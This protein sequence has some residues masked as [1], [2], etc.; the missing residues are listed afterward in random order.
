MHVSLESLP[1]VMSVEQ[2]ASYLGVCRATAYNWCKAGELP[3][4][5]VGNTRRIRKETF[6]VWLDEQEMGG[7]S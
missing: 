4:I 6:L 2:A 3:S 1:P 5:K 7:Q